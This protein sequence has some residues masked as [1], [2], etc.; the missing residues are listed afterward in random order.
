MSAYGITGTLSRIENGTAIYVDS[1]NNP[2][3]LLAAKADH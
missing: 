3:I 2:V 1:N